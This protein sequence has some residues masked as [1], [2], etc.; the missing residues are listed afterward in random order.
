MTAIFPQILFAHAQHKLPPD[1]TEQRAAALLIAALCAPEKIVKHLAN[2]LDATCPPEQPIAQIILS[3]A[4]WLVD[5]TGPYGDLPFAAPF[6][7]DLRG[8][9]AGSGLAPNICGA[10]DFTYAT[11]KGRA[12]LNDDFYADPDDL[13]AA[14]AIVLHL[15]H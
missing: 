4:D 1:L 13:R 9:L 7:P 6:I 5:Q 14:I 8:Y 11:T 10:L 15:L 2:L 12:K 3:A